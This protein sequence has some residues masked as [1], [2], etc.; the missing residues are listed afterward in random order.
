MKKSLLF[1]SLLL[2]LTA[3]GWAASRTAS[4]SGNW[5]NTATWGGD[6][7]P[8]SGDFA[9]I[10]GDVVVTIPAGVTADLG[11][12]YL[13]IGA[14]AN[15]SGIATVINNGT[16]LAERLYVGQGTG[17]D[18]LYT[19]GPDSVTTVSAKFFM[20][21]GQLRST[22]TAGH[23]AKATGAGQFDTNGVAGPT[24]DIQL[25]YL[26]WEMTDTFGPVL[27]ATTGA[28]TSRF[29][30]S[31]CVFAGVASMTLGSATSP[32]ST[33]IS[34]DSSDIR[35]LAGT[36]TITFSRANGGVA[37]F[38]LT[39]STL[40]QTGTD[41]ITV[42]TATSGGLSFT[43]NVTLNVV[44]TEV[45]P[46]ANTISTNFMVINADSGGVIA[47]GDAG[48]ASTVGSNYFYQ[49]YDATYLPLGSNFHPINSTGS[50][51]SGTYQ[52]TG[53]VLEVVYHD[54]TPQGLTFDKGDMWLPGATPLASNAA[55]N[56]VLNCGDVVTA[57]HAKALCSTAMTVK[58]NTVAGNPTQCGGAGVS[59]SGLTWRAEGTLSACAPINI[60]NNLHV[61]NNYAVSEHAFEGSDSGGNQVV[62]YSDYN[63]FYNLGGTA[64]PATG[65]TLTTGATHD[66][67]V[68]PSFVDTT[69]G[70][71]KWNQVR[72]S[73]TNSGQDAITCLLAMNG[74]RGT[75]NFDQGGTACANGPTDLVSWVRA[76]FRP[77]N[78][79][80][81]AAGDPS[82]G[83]PDIGAMPVL[84]GGVC[85]KSLLG[86]GC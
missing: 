33:I 6:P 84:S 75:P 35:D 76:G 49:G 26:S 17:K 45:A 38:G 82:D 3:H 8:V 63:D 36:R 19:F 21:N 64:Y 30:C 9:S 52:I 69:R 79:A 72:G 67:T 46:T 59:D 24:Q 78:A 56:L 57:V 37:T 81:K 29:T 40:R 13:I 22:A 62:A 43:G 16:V 65:W 28:E 70:L 1:L 83:S 66:K 80:L 71:A 15:A 73:G 23:F 42:T 50:G 61:G 60:A 7:V 39:N 41:Q 48:S 44:V 47:L 11:V 32:S 5:N 53:N 58:N 2:L 68:N 77:T 25:S 74:Y 86:V 10:N 31:H 85:T 20:Q 14:S 18:G 54:Y 27:Q 34:I 12:G 55:N 4:V 51:G